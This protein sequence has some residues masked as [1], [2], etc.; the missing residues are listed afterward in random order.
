MSGTT[1]PKFANVACSDGR[2]AFASRNRSHVFPERGYETRKTSV[3]RT[4]RPRAAGGAGAGRDARRTSR[5]VRPKPRIAASLL[6]AFPGTNRRTGGAIEEPASASAE[7]KPRG[8][9]SARLRL[10]PPH[11]VTGFHALRDRER[12]R[13]LEDEEPSLGA[14]EGAGGEE[15]EPRVAVLERREPLSRRELGKL[16]AIT[17]QP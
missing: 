6:R 1:S 10:P 16:V 13:S 7:R 15:R 17:S 3:S 4:V 11:V 14:A 12:I 9:R 2:S 5:S 8:R